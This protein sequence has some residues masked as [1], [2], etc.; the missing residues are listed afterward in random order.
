MFVKEKKDKLVQIRMTEN[1]KKILTELS[2][3][4]N[5]NVSEFILYLVQKFIDDCN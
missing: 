1:Q 3:E 2:K 5:M 4:H